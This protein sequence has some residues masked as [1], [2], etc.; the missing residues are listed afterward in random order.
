MWWLYKVLVAVV[1]IAAI[2]GGLWALVYYNPGG[3]IHR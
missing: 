1:V 3:K 2:I